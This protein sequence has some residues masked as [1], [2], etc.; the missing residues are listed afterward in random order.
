MSLKSTSFFNAALMCRPDVGDFDL[1]GPD[2][3]GQRF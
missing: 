3:V 2:G 1:T